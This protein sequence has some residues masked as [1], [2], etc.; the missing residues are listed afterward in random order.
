MT[1]DDDQGV[2]LPKWVIGAISTLIVTIIIGGVTQGIMLYSQSGITNERLR[3][4]ADKL[5]KMEIRLNQLQESNRDRY[6]I[7]Q[8]NAYAVRVSED[9]RNIQKIIETHANLPWHR[10]AGAEHADA[11][12]RLERIEKIIEELVKRK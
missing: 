3:T 1:Q 7:T 8:H 10:E 5:D 2:F 9:L 12:R 6:T 11:K 4:M